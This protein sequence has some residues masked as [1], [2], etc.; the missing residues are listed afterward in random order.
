[1]TDILLEELTEKD[2]EWLVSIGEKQDLSAGTMLIQ[3]QK[4]LSQFYI[5]L[6]GSL[7]AVVANNPESVLGRAYSALSSDSELEQ[8]LFSLGE[9]DIA[10][11]GAML[12]DVGSPI[13]IRAE[14]EVSAIAVPCQSLQQQLKKS[15][16][17]ASRFYRA[18]ALLLLTRY[19]SLLDQFINRKGIQV[20]PLEETPLIFGELY[21]SDVDWMIEQGTVQAVPAQT[22]LIQGGRATDTLYV[23][24]RGV[25]SISVSEKNPPLSTQCL[26]S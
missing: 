16:E 20:S 26:R 22:T 11:E 9:G 2:L 18:I 1:M 25:L 15:P 24:L 14:T 10:G 4:T 23:V 5:I 17:V 7:N 3:Q 13:A 12:R 8:E 19:E 21:D 6:Q